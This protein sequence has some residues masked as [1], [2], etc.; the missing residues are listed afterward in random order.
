MATLSITGTVTP[1]TGLSLG[2]ASQAVKMNVPQAL[3]LNLESLKTR[4]GTIHPETKQF[5]QLMATQYGVTFWA[6]LDLVRIFLTALGNSSAPMQLGDENG[7]RV[8]TP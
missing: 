6:A 8:Y 5:V 1:L 2:T 3:G 7:S 4:D